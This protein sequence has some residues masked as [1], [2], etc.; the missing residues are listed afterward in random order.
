MD[1]LTTATDAVDK[2]DRVRVSR[3]WGVFAHMAA[4]AVGQAVREDPEAAKPL[5]LRL[6]SH[7]GVTADQA[8]ADFTKTLVS[9]EE[10][11]ER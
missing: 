6:A 4:H 9:I 11:R 3:N 8:E 10:S 5:Y 2:L 7:F 1:W